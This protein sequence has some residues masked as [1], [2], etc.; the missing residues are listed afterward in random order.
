[1]AAEALTPASAIA[2]TMELDATEIRDGSLGLLDQ[3]IVPVGDW[4]WSR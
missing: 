3:L 1:M 4:M 2:F